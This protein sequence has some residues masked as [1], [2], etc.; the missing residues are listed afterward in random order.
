MNAKP[1]S[2][3]QKGR[4][5]VDTTEATESRPVLRIVHPTDFSAA[6]DVAFGH[7]LKLALVTRAELDLLHVSRQRN[8]IGWEAFPGVRAMLERWGI[9]Q[10]DRASA[11]PASAGLR[12]GKIVGVDTD[13]VR[14]VVDYVGEHPTDLVVLATHQRSGIERWLHA[15]TAE[16]IARR[17]H[18]MTLFIPPGA[19][20]FVSAE[21]GEV[22]LRR[23]LVPVD[24]APAPQPAVDATAAL[25]GGVGCAEA[26]VVLLHVGAEANLPAVK[27][28]L[29]G[30][31]R[32]EWAVREGEPVA[33]ILEVAAGMAAELI[34]MT[35]Q[36]HRGLA[37]ALQGSTTERVIRRARCPVLAV[38]EGS[39]AMVR[40]F[41]R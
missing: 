13:P 34:V 38:P 26:S 16:P 8:R 28:P 10:P 12:V 27:T 3:G 40:L 22:T 6:S 15:A 20:G 9:P 41:F 5:V 35:T 11:P 29:G 37:D 17:A 23:I 24:R 32:W 39:R 31:G 25:L 19:G 1:D 7:A 36:G 2:A 30:G 21:T 14:S 18:E 33:R 4:G